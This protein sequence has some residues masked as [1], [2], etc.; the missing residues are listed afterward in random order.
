MLKIYRNNI[1]YKEVEASLCCEIP[2]LEYGDEIRDAN[3]KPLYR[4]GL[5]EVQH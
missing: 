1:L 5:V 3:D 4:V 2:G